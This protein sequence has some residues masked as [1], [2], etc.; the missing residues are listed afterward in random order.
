LRS[1]ISK[2]QARENDLSHF[3]R[4]APQGALAH[5]L[6]LTRGASPSWA[7]RKGA[8]L[9]RSVA[10]RAMKG[11]A[12]DVEALGARM[13]LYPYDSLRDQWLLFTPQ[14]F[15]PAERR[16][17]EAC[18]PQDAV[19]IDIGAGFGGYSLFAAAAT[20]AA[21]RIL[22]IEPNPET[23]E[24]LVF[25]IGQN[26]FATVKAL[27][28]AIADHDGEML[29]IIDPP[30]G[31]FRVA[32]GAKERLLEERVKIPTKSLA[33]LVRE[34]KLDRID[35]LRLDVGGAE[36]LILD[37]FLRAVPEALWPRFLFAE[38][39]SDQLAGEFWER[40][41]TLHYRPLLKSARKGIFER[42]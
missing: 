10:A 14:Y 37:P 42:C 15:D 22:A 39:A 30:R 26:S 8:F 12:L 6:N 36:N 34:E 20:G 24:R 40:V 32:G 21:A 2:T 11:R 5:L 31:A 17:L 38:F 13:R 1:D 16:C 28:C 19:F 41:A 3:G 9:V 25:N 7:G 27:A 18:M 35:V 23:F 29:L 4:Y 33:T